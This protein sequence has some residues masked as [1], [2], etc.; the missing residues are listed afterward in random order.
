M[1]EMKDELEK[2]LPKWETVIKG[3]KT[4]AKLGFEN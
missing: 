1:P 3:G 2:K 4:E